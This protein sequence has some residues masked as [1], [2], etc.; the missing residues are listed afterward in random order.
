MVVT[1]ADV[2]EDVIF[3]ERPRCPHCSEEM[4]ICESGD[5]ALSCGSGWGTPYLFVCMNNECPPFVQGWEN[6]RKNFGRKFSCRCICFPDSRKT[7]SML[8]TSYGDGRSEVI[9]EETIR[10]DRVRGTEE[11]PEVQALNRSFDAG[12]VEAL[13]S[14]LFDSKVYY[15][16]R[17]K[18]AALIGE[19][20]MAEAVEP[21]LHHRFM[22]RRVADPARKAIQRI[23]EVA[24]SRECPFCTEVIDDGIAVCSE[25]GRELEKSGGNCHE[26]TKN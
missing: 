11:D 8:V 21:L 19:L 9:A 15:K 6:M 3:A 18:A 4:K 12:E 22:D 20:G 24:G 1:K 13:L 26:N 25:C 10:R 7:E 16:V 23:H 17:Q 5:S 14:I 2:Y